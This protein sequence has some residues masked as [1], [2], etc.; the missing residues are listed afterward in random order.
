MISGLVKAQLGFHV[1]AN[2]ATIAAVVLLVVATGARRA[3]A[4]TPT[5]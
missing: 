1:L 2:G 5:R 4:S 3:M